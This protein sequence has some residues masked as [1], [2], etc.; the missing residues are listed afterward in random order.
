[1]AIMNMP[2]A[3]E[4]AMENQSKGE[5]NLS[6]YK[7]APEEAGAVFTNEIIVS[8]MY[9]GR[10]KLFNPD[11]TMIDMYG[12]TGAGIGLPDGSELVTFYLKLPVHGIPNY[13]RP[14]GSIGYTYVVCPNAL[15]EYLQNTFS[16]APLFHDSV[17][18]AFCQERQRWWDVSNS[19]WSE[20]GLKVWDLKGEA[21]TAKIK[22]DSVLSNAHE[23][24]GKYRVMDRYPMNVFDYSKQSG[25]RPL[26]EGQEYVG[27]QAWFAPKPVFESLRSHYEEGWDFWNLDRPDGVQII[28]VTKDTT[29]VTAQKPWKTSYAVTMAPQR[30]MIQPEILKYLGDPNNQVDP[31]NFVAVSSYEAM[32]AHIQNANNPPQ[33][34]T[35]NRTYSGPAPQTSTPMNP[36]P[37]TPVTPVAPTMPSTAPTYPSSSGLP[38]VPTTPQV[39]PPASTPSPVIP[40]VAQPQAS[41]TPPVPTTPVRPPVPVGPLTTSAAAPPKPVTPN[42]IPSIA[43]PDRTPPQDGGA[44]EPPVNPTGPSLGGRS[45]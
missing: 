6:I 24:A 10:W 36:T 42:P 37:T 34:S 30:I 19:R 9:P 28:K 17:Q 11:Q 16:G 8:L 7:P 40:P 33:V 4:K 25:S 3:K 5:G 22:S 15:N 12:M 26:D 1:M 18:C 31:S 13:K 41:V 29:E 27:L 45:W 38:P 35:Q 21:R 32:V 23:M 39:V 44:A 2:V 43:L 20:L 14:D